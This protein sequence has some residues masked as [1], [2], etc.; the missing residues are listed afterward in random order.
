M[1]RRVPFGQSQHAALLVAA[2]IAF[3]AASLVVAYGVFAPPGHGKPI[4]PWDKAEHF[5]AFFGLMG[6]A[7]LA[8][9]ATSLVVLAVAL[10]FAGAMVEVIQATPLVGRDADVW[11]WVADTIGILAIVGTVIGAKLRRMLADR[12]G[13]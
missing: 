10:S 6:L 5:T 12:W 7:L 4:M 11:D 1:S 2:R 8:F 9:P 13:G 3:T